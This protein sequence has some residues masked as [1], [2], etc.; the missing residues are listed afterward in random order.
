LGN[1]PRI[2]LRRRIKGR[3]GAASRDVN[4]RGVALRA[5]SPLVKAACHP[6]EGRRRILAL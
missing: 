4:R 5:F 6:E 1:E 2:A 3:A